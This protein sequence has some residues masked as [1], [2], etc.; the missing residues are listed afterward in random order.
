MR[1]STVQPTK[2]D[3]PK[4]D[5]PSLG[6]RLMSL[7]VALIY[8]GFLASLPLDV[9]KDRVNYLHYAAYSW[10]VL[11]RFWSQ[12]PL[13]ALAN[14]PIWLL[15]NSGLAIFLPTDIS[16]RIIIF[17]PAAIV[18]WIVLLQ[19]P[20][21][22]I[23]LLLFLVHPLVIKNHI[24]HLRQGMA[25]AVFLLGWFSE[26]KPIRWLLM[27]CA[28]FIHS[29]FLFVLGLLGIAKIAIKLRLGPDLRTL[30]FV[31][32]GIISGLG[33]SW[34]A[35]F[36]GARQVFDYK[37]AMAADASGLGFIFWAMV[38]V[39]MYLQGGAYM[40]LYAFELG[41]ML[42]YLTT[43]LFIEVAARIFESAILLVLL[44]GLK[45]TGWRSKVFRA[46]ILS[47]AALLYASRFGQPWLGWGI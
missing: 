23:W 41:T 11:N 19:S 34:L 29:S 1:Y 17:V 42:F 45:L 40:R 12:S 37:F 35:A 39:V 2:S 7:M 13:V 33:L 27:G 8:G 14:E 18:A 20:R 28:P 44:A 26:Y 30:L 38:F 6:Y 31:A 3:Q 5:R 36:I 16:L 47:L 10:D 22:F 15:I 25:I 32:V 21:N 24:I 4:I 43:Y 9:F 46:M